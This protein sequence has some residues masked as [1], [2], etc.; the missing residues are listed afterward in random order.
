MRRLTGFWLAI[1]VFLV[2]LALVSFL[3]SHALIDVFSERIETLEHLNKIIKEEKRW[4][5]IQDQV[6]IDIEFGAESSKFLDKNLVKGM[7]EATDK[8]HFIVY[9]K[10]PTKSA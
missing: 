7:T 3:V 9:L 5:N 8:K 1:P 2:G 6:N 10:K 4:L